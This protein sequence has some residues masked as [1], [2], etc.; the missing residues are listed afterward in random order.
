MTTP[1]FSGPLYA[2]VADLRLWLSSTDSGVGTPAQLDDSQLTLC[3]YSASNRVSVYAGGL[4]DGSTPVAMPP[5]VFHDLTLDLAA[6]FAWRTYLKGKV[7]PSDHPVFVAYQNATQ[8]LNDVRDGKIVLEITTAG[9]IGP[10]QSALIINRIPPIFTG[11][12]SNTRV[13]VSGY[14][15]DDIPAGLWSP[16]SL[17]WG[18]GGPIYQG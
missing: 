8:M 7:I 14:L 10:G 16:R 4:F 15:E 17:D 12:D 3:L 2:S 13:G 18:S 11:S 5:P 9:A 6:F 1:T